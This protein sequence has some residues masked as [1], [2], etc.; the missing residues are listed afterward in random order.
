VFKQ[1]LY[2]PGLEYQETVFMVLQYGWA[3]YETLFMTIYDHPVAT[4]F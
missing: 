4:R 3:T 1:F 2:V